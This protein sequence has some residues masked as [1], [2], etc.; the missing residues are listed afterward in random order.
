MRRILP[1]ILALWGIATLHA[2]EKKLPPP[3]SPAIQRAADFAA[4]TVR[5]TYPKDKAKAQGEENPAPIPERVTALSVRK[6]NQTYHVLTEWQSGRKSEKWIIDGVQLQTAPGST[7]VSLLPKPE[8]AEF[9]QPDYLDF[10]QGDFPELD[11]VSL[12]DY[13]GVQPYEGQPAYFF[14]SET[15]SKRSVFL[16]ERQLPLQADFGSVVFTYTMGTPPATPLIP[17]QNFAQALAIHKRG[18]EALRRHASPP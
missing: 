14:T 16:S 8:S 17:P 18:K 12:N 3:T 2:Q 10:S 15:G 7:V 6:T 1:I 13:R 9:A 4:W 11:W 5:F